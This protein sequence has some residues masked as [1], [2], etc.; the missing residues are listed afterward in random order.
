MEQQNSSLRQNW[1]VYMLRCADGS[2][3]TGITTDL[4]RRL[5]EHN[6]QLSGK[7]ARY[8]QGRR[9]VVLVWQE[10]NHDRSSALKREY[11]VKRFSRKAKLQ[12]CT[13]CSVSK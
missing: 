3:Y 2:L 11:A 4:E 5:G 6:G 13:G 12:L 8:T 7:G 9:P 10:D 1:I